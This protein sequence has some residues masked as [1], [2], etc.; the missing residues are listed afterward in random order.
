MEVNGSEE[1][2]ESKATGD[3]SETPD[4]DPNPD[5]R[6]RTV[7]TKV[8]E[9]D[10]RLFNRGK[11][12]IATF[13]SSLGGWD[14]DR[15][16]VQEILEMYGFKT[17]Y[18]FSPSSGRGVPIRFDPKKGRSILPYTDGSLVLLDGEPKVINFVSFYCVMFW[19]IDL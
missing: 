16:E 18:S 5:L 11:G 13:H 1:I 8:P 10:V 19:G 14:Q 15:L 9:V 2:E 3:P 12:P 17:I 7:R 4:S 6:R